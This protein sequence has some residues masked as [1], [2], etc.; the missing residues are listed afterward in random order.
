MNNV[1]PGLTVTVSGG[2]DPDNYYVEFTGADNEAQPWGQMIGT[3]LDDDGYV[4]VS[5]TQQGKAGGEPI[6]SAERGWPACGRFMQQRLVMT[7]LAGM[8][9]AILASIVGDP[10]DLDPETGTAAAGFSYEI[11]VTQSSEMRDIVVGRTILFLGDADIVYLKNTVLSAEDAPQFGVGAAPGITPDVAPVTS[12]NAIYYIQEG[13]SSL[14]QTTYN[15]LED[16]VVA[17][18]ASVL[19][20]FLVRN[21]VGL[22]RQRS[23]NRLDADLLVIVNSDGSATVLTNM[24]SQE[25]SGFAPGSR[26][27]PC[28]RPR[29]TTPTSCG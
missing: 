22:A 12:N 11:D 7:G 19:S 3:A 2:T 14:Q 9:K 29:W 23:N 24:R 16:N 21:A 28:S 1:G 4:S 5:T 17:D 27:A 20:A 18:N 25:V 6:M 8:P 26:M 15:Q 10:Y 13:G